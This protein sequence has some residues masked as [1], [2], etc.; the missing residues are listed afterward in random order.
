MDTLTRANTGLCDERHW[1]DLHGLREVLE[2]VRSNHLGI[3]SRCKLTFDRYDY[4]IQASLVNPPENLPQLLTA[5]QKKF[6]DAVN[7]KSGLNYFD[8][9][10]SEV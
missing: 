2:E 1:R 10:E 5:R 4:L 7:G 6:V 8:A 3:L 9:L